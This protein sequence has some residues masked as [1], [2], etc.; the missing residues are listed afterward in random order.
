MTDELLQDILEQTKKEA[1]FSKMIAF[2]MLLMLIILIIVLL[3]LVPR[4]LSMFSEIEK[5][6]KD[7]QIMVE[8]ANTTL[9]EL[10]TTLDG[11]GEMTESITKTGDALFEGIGKVDF[12]A[13]SK[14]VTDLQEAVEPLA[15]FSRVLSGR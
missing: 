9:E 11:V 6:A 14:A 10:G 15:N 2:L 1:G 5:T 13:L 7:A 12:D 8:Q 4:A 3:L